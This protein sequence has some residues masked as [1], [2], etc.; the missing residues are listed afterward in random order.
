MHTTDINPI[1]YIIWLKI[2]KDHLLRSSPLMISTAAAKIH[3]LLVAQE[4]KSH[5]QG[6]NNHKLTEFFLAG[7][8]QGFKTGFKMGN[9]SLKSVAKN[10]PGALLHPEVV[11]KYLQHELSQ[12]RLSGPY[13]ATSCSQAHISRF[14]VIPKDH[15]PGKW[16]LIVDLSHPAGHSINNGIPPSLCSLSYVTVDDAMQNIIKTGPGTSL[17]KIDIKSAFQLLPICLSDHHLVAMQRKQQVYIDTYLP[18][19]L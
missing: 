18:F 10:L 8:T 12:H 17:A 19:R 5:L 14:G 1:P 6:Y 7:I 3:T 13:P 15:Q 9:I 4:W 2:W 11:D 16:C